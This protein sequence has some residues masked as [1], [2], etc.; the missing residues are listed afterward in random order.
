MKKYPRVSIIVLNWNGWKD[1]IECLNSLKKIAYPNYEVI[2]IDN[3]STDGSVERLKAKSLK[4]K[5]V[6]NNKNL[7]FAEGNN[8]AI[9]RVLKENK[10]DFVLLL[11]NDTVV[12]KNFLTKL[13]KTTQKEE[14]IGIVGPK[15]Y[16][17]D[18]R[19]VI[20]SAG[21]KINLYLGKFPQ[22][23][24]KK[25]TEVDFVT[26]ACL[27]I[28][29]EVIKKIGLLDKKFFL[30]FEDMDWCVRAKKASY[31]ILYVPGSIIWHKTGRSF[32]KE[33]VSRTYYY[34]R[35]LFRFEF[36]HANHL[37]LLCFLFSYFVL[38]FPVYFLGYLFIKRNYDLWKNYVRGVRE[39]VFTR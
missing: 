13:V 21:S 6:F 28:K 20:Q 22:I 19:N 10:S 33:N 4:L 38:V 29:T 35:N 18:K 25:T 8:I 9:R 2:V 17:F 1:T 36:K 16:Y 23:K 12:E 3:G 11:N 5:A 7:G 39:G 26:G 37:Q 32:K 15:I 14:R 34:T 27:L 31:L 30:I 24:S